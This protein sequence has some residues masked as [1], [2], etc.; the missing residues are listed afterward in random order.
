[1]VQSDSKERRRLHDGP[2]A[3]ARVR[4]VM[5]NAAINWRDCA[6]DFD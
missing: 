5:F 1:M 4:T 3:V 6:V 2:Y